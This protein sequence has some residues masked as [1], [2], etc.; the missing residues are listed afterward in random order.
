M[1]K[2][3]KKPGDHIILRLKN[4]ESPLV[5]EWMNRQSNLSDAIRYLIEEEIRANAVRDLQEYVPAKRKPLALV[6]LERH[7]VGAEPEKEKPD[8]QERESEPETETAE[9][10]T[11]KADEVDKKEESEEEYSDDIIDHWMNI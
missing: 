6:E 2:K 3:E 1:A 5:L 7:E 4:N 11:G 9:A 10:E 8:R